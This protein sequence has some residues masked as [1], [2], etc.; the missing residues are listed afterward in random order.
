VFGITG[1]GKSN[2]LGVIVFGL[3]LRG[4]HITILD[5]PKGTGYL[6]FTGYAR[7]VHTIDDCADALDAEYA[8]LEAR[9]TAARQLADT[10]P[11]VDGD[12]L[13]RWVVCDRGER[14]VVI[15][16]LPLLHPRKG[17]LQRDPGYQDNQTRKRAF[18]RFLDLLALGRQAGFHVIVGAR[19]AHAEAFDSTEHRAQLDQLVTG[20]QD[21]TGATLLGLPAAALL[22]R[23]TAGRALLAV[24]GSGTSVE[25]QSYRRPT[26]TDIRQRL[27]AAGRSPAATAAGFAGAAPLAGGGASSARRLS[28]S[29]AAQASDVGLNG[30][31]RARRNGDG[32]P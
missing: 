16:E 24:A 14:A 4:V 17:V 6:E 2:L 19:S 7:I 23:D 26:P 28:A 27:T 18:Q 5:H 21:P 12:T 30:D 25:Y 31:G 13:M 3:L 15:D 1:S 8:E 32:G 29:R 22:D 10:H 11:L 9:H 20:R